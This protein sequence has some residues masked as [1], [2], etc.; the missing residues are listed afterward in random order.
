MSTP[1]I[2]TNRLARQV[3][4]SE[5]MALRDAT[6]TIN[7]GEFVAIVGAS[8]SGKTTLLSLL[9]LLD[10]P[11]SGTYMLAGQDVSRLTEAERDKERGRRFGFVFQN[12]YVVPEQSVAENVDLGLR[13]QGVDQKNRESLV[14]DAL[15]TVGL[16][17]HAHR[18]AGTL[19]GGE[20]Q[21]VALARALITNPDAILADEPTGALDSESSIRLVERLKKISETG[22]TV[23]I[24]T[25]DPLVA[26]AADRQITI[27]DGVAT[28]PAAQPWLLDS[29]SADPPPSSVSPP[30]EQGTRRRR[31]FGV[32]ADAV[33]AP[34]AKPGRWF[35]VVVAYML[36]VAALV[37][38]V[39]LTSSATGRIVD[40]L[41][42]AGSNEI[43]VF[44][45]HNDDNTG[46]LD[47]VTSTGAAQRLG[48]LE[49]VA[50]AAPLITY[51]SNGA[52][53]TRLGL[54]SETPINARL[55]VSDSRYLTILKLQ[56]ASGRLDLLDVP[57]AD[58]VAVLG[59]RAADSLHIA[60][61]D[62]GVSINVSGRTI[63]V[64]AVLQETGDALRDNAVYFS[65]PSAILL[66][67]WVD[68]CI[69]VVTQPG[70][71]EPLAQ[72]IPLFLSPENPGAVTV[73]IV[74]QL[75]NLQQSVTQDLSRLLGIVG[76][77]V[78]VLSALTAG[79]SMFLTITHRAAHIALRRAL[80]AS[81]ASIWWMHTIEGLWTGMIGASL[82]VGA[83]VLLTWILTRATGLPL[84]LGWTIVALGL[85]MG[86]I[87][88]A[89]ASMYPAWSAAHKDPATILRE[90]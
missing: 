50:I 16:S 32:F 45:S 12:S 51:S 54:P 9:G 23:I 2:S 64:V 33:V 17:R 29:D 78:L 82:G 37:A 25:H 80:G 79:V 49:G 87:I 61:A 47:P 74:A 38:S 18:N 59:S 76:G 8:G 14:K 27:E 62:P 57:E 11:S 48:E 68:R 6:V 63:P 67:N 70:Y 53:I 86:I 24:V 31:V 4:G 5:Q 35:L 26:A 56:A 85:G 41:T 10:H 21:R 34:L 7:S 69:L 71:A 30:Q 84:H 88:G 20:K 15:D 58:A 22:V 66:S 43:R 90:A 77:V 81:R 75:A 28:S 13:I 83:G 1:L 39:G 36:G 72:A 40:T 73:T 44:S 55:S 3:P 65:F 46:F 60:A 42:A 89:L 52:F 19:S